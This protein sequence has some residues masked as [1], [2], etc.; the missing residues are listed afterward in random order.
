MMYNLVGILLCIAAVYFFSRAIDA[1]PE[2][3]EEL[4]RLREN[5]RRREAARRK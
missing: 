1:W 5:R 4:D 2:F 3:R